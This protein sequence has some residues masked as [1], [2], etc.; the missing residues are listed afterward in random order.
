MNDLGCFGG[1]HTGPVLAVLILWFAV[2]LG[3]LL[4]WQ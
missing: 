4:L 3:L 1:S 2:G